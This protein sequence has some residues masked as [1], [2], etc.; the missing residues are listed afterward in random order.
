MP[1]NPPAGDNET[2]PQYHGSQSTP[3]PGNTP[4]TG[5]LTGPEVTGR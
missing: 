5:A 2:Q 3:K 4:V 1:R